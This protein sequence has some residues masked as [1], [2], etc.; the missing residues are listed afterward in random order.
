MTRNIKA[1]DAVIVADE[2][3]V[4]HDG[5]VTEAWVSATGGQYD[6]QRGP[7]INVVFVS[8][9]EKKTDQF[10]RQIEHLSSVAHRSMKG[11]C[12]GRYWYQP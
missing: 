8:G 4:E 2:F 1:G 9:D 6:D 12:P 11:E 7:A 5:L 3:G 10:G